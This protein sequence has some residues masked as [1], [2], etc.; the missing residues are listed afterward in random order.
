ML[1]ASVAPFRGT[2][3]DNRVQLVNEENDLPLAGDD[4]L[5]EGL[6]PILEFAAKFGAGDHRAEI[7]GDE[8]LVLQASRARRR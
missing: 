4:L 2:R 6:E 7:H 8:P 1:A 3:A 5:E